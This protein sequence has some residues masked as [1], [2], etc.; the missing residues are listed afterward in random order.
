MKKQEKEHEQKCSERRNYS[1]TERNKRTRITR[2]KMRVK[3][4][5]NRTNQII[6]ILIRSLL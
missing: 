4:E 2:R 6:S 5:E 3:T 1:I